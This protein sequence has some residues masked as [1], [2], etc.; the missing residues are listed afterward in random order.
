LWSLPGDG[1]N[2]A[3]FKHV[4][5]QLVAR[6]EVAPPQRAAV[7]FV[8]FVLLTGLSLPVAGVMVLAAGAIFGLLWG[9][10]IAL[11]ASA[12][13]AAIALL[14]AR[15]LFRDAVESRFGNR[16]ATINRGIEQGGSPY[17]FMLRFAPVFPFFIVNAATELSRISSVDNVLSPPLAVSLVLLGG[18][19]IAARKTAGLC[20]RSRT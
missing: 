4:Q 19:P 3:Q 9:T 14:A 13:G 16:L 12:A 6:Y 18:L 11:S 5:V 2:L 17:L 1:F 20:R 10:A 7:P 8:V 15:F